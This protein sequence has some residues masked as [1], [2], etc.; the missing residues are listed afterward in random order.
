MIDISWWVGL[1]NNLLIAC[2]AVQMFTVTFLFV[3]KLY[4]QDN[5]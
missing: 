1:N 3:I 5:I 2:I 4:K